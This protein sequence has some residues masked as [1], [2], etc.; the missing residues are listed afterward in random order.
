MLCTFRAN[1]PAHIETDASDLAIGACLCQQRDDK[2]HPIAYYS[3]KMSAA[4]QNYDIHDKELLAVVYALQNWRVYAE[5]YS[6]LTIFT[7]HKNL[8]NFTTTK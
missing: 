4:E 1:E 3:R 7:D 6:E 2:W 5:S 8:L